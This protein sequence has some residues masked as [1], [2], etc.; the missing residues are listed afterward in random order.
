MTEEN[1]PA[2]KN[3]K[4]YQNPGSCY[5]LEPASKF[6]WERRYLQ[7]NDLGHMD[8]WTILLTFQGPVLALGQIVGSTDLLPYRTAFTKLGFNGMFLVFMFSLVL[9]FLLERVWV[10]VGE[11]ERDSLK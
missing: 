7:V 1:I 5:K 8:M 6:S 3:E 10:G 2:F 9:F 4:K 11:R